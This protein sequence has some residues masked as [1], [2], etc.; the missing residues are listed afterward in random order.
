MVIRIIAMKTHRDDRDSHWMAT[1]FDHPF[2]VCCKKPL[3]KLACL[4]GSTFSQKFSA[5]RITC[6]LGSHFNTHLIGGRKC[7][8]CLIF[9]KNTTNRHL[10]IM[11]LGK[12]WG[13]TPGTCNSLDDF[14]RFLL[15]DIKLEVTKYCKGHPNEWQILGFA[16]SHVIFI[17]YPLWFVLAKKSPLCTCSQANF[18]HFWLGFKQPKVSQQL[19]KPIFL[20]QWHC[21]FRHGQGSCL[22]GSL[23]QRV[24]WR[25]GGRNKHFPA[26]CYRPMG[27]GFPAAKNWKIHG[28]KEKKH[29]R[30]P[31][32]FI[33]LASSLPPPGTY[34]TNPL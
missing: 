12:T 33:N 2:F 21:F 30:H 5:P 4:F 28:Q 9:K 22:H 11:N 7:G 8:C 31:S 23:A 17:L 16:S 14:A 18:I 25:F 15:H 13:F 20:R 34:Q 24:G 32:T 26:T 3:K 29:T 6:Q 27:L 10:L 19:P 1:D